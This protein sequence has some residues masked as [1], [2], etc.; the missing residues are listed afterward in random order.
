MTSS[1]RL[2]LPAPEGE[3]S[4]LNPVV[5]VMTVYGRYVHITMRAFPG[6]CASDTPH[7]GFAVWGV[8]GA[9]VGCGC[10]CATIRV[11]IIVANPGSPGVEWDAIYRHFYDGPVPRNLE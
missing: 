6:A 8:V 9:G 3:N 7:G 11:G 5:V 1:T 4:R 2:Q 10:G